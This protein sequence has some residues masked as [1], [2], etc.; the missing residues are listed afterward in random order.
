MR[1]RSL[2]LLATVIA[3]GAL[4][5]AACSDGEDAAP[6]E[7]DHGDE[8]VFEMDAETVLHHWQALAA[9]RAGDLDDAQ[10]H[11]EHIAEVVSADEAHASAMHEIL[12]SLD[13][14]D[15][16][17]AEHGIQVMLVGRA[18]QEVTA[19]L[20]HLQMA[21]AA[22]GGGKASEAMHHLEHFVA[23]AHDDEAGEG[24]EIVEFLERG[25]LGEAS[26]HLEALIDGLISG[27]TH[28]ESDDAH[29]AGESDTRTVTITMREFSYGPVEIH[30]KVG[31]R[32]R[33]VLVNKG[34]VL[35]DITTDSFKGEVETEASAEHHGDHPA[36]GEGPN[37]HAAANAGET[38]ELT[39]VAEEAGRLE[40]YCTVPGHRELGMTAL[41]IVDADDHAA[42]DDSADEHDDEHEDQAAAH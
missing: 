32:V 10:H 37:F 36:E 2:W 23:V 34:V 35:H 12:A 9:I 8:M 14:A 39:F 6:V 3:V 15:V 22:L 41:L 27:N 38:V 18:E 16:H 31:E 40:L 17:D 7:D 33:L 1:R 24:S 30:A 4:L 13:A 11:V 28:A 20:V 21:I 19:E 42:A 25:D 29:E 5:G 26:E